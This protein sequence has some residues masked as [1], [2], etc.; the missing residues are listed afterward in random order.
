MLNHLPLEH[1]DAINRRIRIHLDD[2]LRP[3]GVH[4]LQVLPVALDDQ[5]LEG[6]FVRIFQANDDVSAAE[7]RSLGVDED[8]S[9][10]FEQ[11][12]KWPCDDGASP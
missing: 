4:S 3:V 1:D 6:R 2:P 9:A 10:R 12:K 5:L 11:K 7:W 8:R